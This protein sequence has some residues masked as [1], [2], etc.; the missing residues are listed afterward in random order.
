MELVTPAWAEVL[1][2][3][4][5]DEVLP[6]KYRDHA[7]TGDWNGCRDC[8]V[9]PDLVLIYEYQNHDLILHRLGPHSELFG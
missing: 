3:L 2:C 4:C 1:S 7:L 6:E 8:H 9:R 5:N